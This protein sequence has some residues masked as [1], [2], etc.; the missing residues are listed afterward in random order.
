MFFEIV[1]VS[2]NDVRHRKFAPML[3]LTALAKHGLL[4]VDD[5]LVYRRVF[6]DLGITVEKDILVR[7]SLPSLIFSAVS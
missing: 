4:Q 3:D 1:L 7:L 2:D 5:V 6:Q